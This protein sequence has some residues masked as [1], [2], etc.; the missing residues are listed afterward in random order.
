MKTK[1]LSEQ[2]AL[3]TGGATGIGRAFAQGLLAA[4]IGN[5]IIASRRRKVLDAAAAKM[6]AE[7]GDRVTPYAFD[8]RDRSQT[9]DLV[10][11]AKD[12]F[13]AV[14]ILINNSGLAVPE[15]V[16]EITADG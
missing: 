12:K 7:F 10:R 15:S 1:P 11:F 16:I 9:A 8:I 2:T 5:V 3:I 13:G 4:G 14:D 6:N